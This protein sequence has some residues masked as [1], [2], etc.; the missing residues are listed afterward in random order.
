M[1][2]NH[3]P[4]H[5]AAGAASSGVIGLVRSRRVGLLLAGGSL[6]A[7]AA[8]GAAV[9]H[10][11]PATTSPPAVGQS[12]V[13]PANVVHGDDA[14][15]SENESGSGSST[16]A[17]RSRAAGSSLGTAPFASSGSPTIVS[18]GSVPVP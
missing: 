12:A 9:A 8:L 18:G 16:P 14:T 6:A 10:D 2:P 17:S 5:G 1:Q 15:S 4:S 3:K 7:C 11:I 13:S